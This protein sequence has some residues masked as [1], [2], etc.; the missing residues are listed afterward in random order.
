MIVGG[1]DPHRHDL[2]S[3]IMLKDNHIWSSGSFT[4]SFYPLQ[5]TASVI[6]SNIHLSLF[7]FSIFPGSITSAIQQA[8]SVGGFS[9]LLDVEVQ[10][11]AEA[12]EAIGAGADVIMLDNIDGP[13]LQDVARRLKKRWSG[14][15]KFLLESSGNITE[16]N[17]N[18][19]AVEGA[20]CPLSSAILGSRANV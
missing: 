14:K 16:S 4:P 19:R 3:M 2:S 18:Y 17:L 11:E 9:L 15:R 12:D 1:I 7:L 13:E 20:F 6:G 8:R 5:S 10:S